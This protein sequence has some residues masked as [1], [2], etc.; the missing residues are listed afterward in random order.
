MGHTEHF[1]SALLANNGCMGFYRHET[2]LEAI[3][4]VADALAKGWI[5]TYFSV[6]TAYPP[7]PSKLLATARAK[8]QVS[9]QDHFWD[10]DDHIPW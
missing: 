5:G 2:L 4:S 1:Q 10:L 9:A 7:C 6:I 8:H 3:D